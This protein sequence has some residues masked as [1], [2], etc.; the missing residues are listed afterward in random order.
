MRQR[1]L[2][3]FV[4]VFTLI[5]AQAAFAQPAP[6]RLE[7]RAAVLAGFQHTPELNEE[8]QKS[9]ADARRGQTLDEH[10]KL[11]DDGRDAPLHLRRGRALKECDWGLHYED[12]PVLAAAAARPL[13]QPRPACRPAHWHRLAGA[14]EGARSRTRSTPSPSPA[15]PRR[16]HRVATAQLAI[17]QMATESPGRHGRGLDP[18][19]AGPGGE[20]AGIPAPRRVA[21]RHDED[22]EGVLLRLGPHQAARDEGRRAVA[23]DHPQAAGRPVGARWSRRSS[24][25]AAH[26]RGAGAAR[27][28]RAPYYGEVAKI[29]PLPRTS[30]SPAT[31]SCGPGWRRT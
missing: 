23:G 5:A 27:R 22:G 25:P 26:A 24:R 4:V 15:T 10:V 12:G 29:L 18:A 17:E 19:G 13:P 21:R 6:G 2:S 9:L 1:I 31:R 11:L 28:L 3:A 20:A 7:Q 16:R 30:S 8:R 14:T